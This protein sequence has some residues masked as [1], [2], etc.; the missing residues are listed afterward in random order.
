[1]ENSG[2]DANRERACIL[3]DWLIASFA[4]KHSAESESIGQR[5]I[6]VDRLSC[7]TIR[8]KADFEFDAFIPLFSCLTSHIEQL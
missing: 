1:M 8:L 3:A 5:V 6:M 7:V 2:A 4:F